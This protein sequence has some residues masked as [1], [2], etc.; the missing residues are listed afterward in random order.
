MPGKARILACDPTTGL[1][2]TWKVSVVQSPASIS[3]LGDLCILV[4]PVATHR[5]GRKDSMQ[6]S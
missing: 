3:W 1:T 4:S 2:H 5:M 6:R